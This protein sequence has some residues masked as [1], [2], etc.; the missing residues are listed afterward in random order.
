MRHSG[1]RRHDSRA[2]HSGTGSGRCRSCSPTAWF[3]PKRCRR[4]SRDTARRPRAADERT[5]S[6]GHRGSLRPSSPARHR[7]DDFDSRLAGAS[8]RRVA[9]DHRR[10]RQ[11]SGFA[12][13]APASRPRV[14]DARMACRCRHLRGAAA[15]FDRSRQ[16]PS[17]AGR[18]RRVVS[19]S[20]RCTSCAGR[21]SGSTMRRAA[22]IS[23]STTTSRTSDT[24]IRPWYVPL[25]NRVH[26]W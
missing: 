25:R 24:A 20:S 21:A 18:W 16:A 4:S 15:G 8:H 14:A 7:R 6:C 10:G 12:R 17:I 2:L 19:T 23:T 5:G 11:R 13:P 3:R 9:P 22:P 26:C 1:F